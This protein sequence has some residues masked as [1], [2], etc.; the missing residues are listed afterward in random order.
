LNKPSSD[1]I[2]C[3]QENKHSNQ[4]HRFNEHS[5][6][7]YISSISPHWHQN[8]LFPGP[9]GRKTSSPMLP[10]RDAKTALNGIVHSSTNT[11]PAN[12]YLQIKDSKAKKE[13]KKAKRRKR[14]K[15]HVSMMKAKR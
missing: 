5:T 2:A 1:S 8:S 13:G 7:R 15:Y 6:L 11:Y 3:S 9:V 4:I 10:G 12:C 14:R